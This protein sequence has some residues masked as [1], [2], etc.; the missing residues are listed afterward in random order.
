MTDPADDYPLPFFLRVA[1]EWKDIDEFHQEEEM[2][3]RYMRRAPLTGAVAFT[4]LHED[5]Q[6]S[7]LGVTP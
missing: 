1:A 7:D 2:I 3:G 6:F 5:V 4:G